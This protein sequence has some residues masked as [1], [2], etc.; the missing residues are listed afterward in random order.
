M[1]SSVTKSVSA[2]FL[3]GAIF[4]HLYPAQASASQ[5]TPPPDPAGLEFMVSIDEVHQNFVFAETFTGSY[6]R[7]VVLSDGSVRAIELTPMIH[8]GKAVVEFK[9]TGAR[10]YMGLDGTTTNGRLMVQIRDVAASI[11]SSKSQGW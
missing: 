9:D 5:A 6:K 2:G 7:D 4:S 10:T 11:E 8:D 3:A 1:P